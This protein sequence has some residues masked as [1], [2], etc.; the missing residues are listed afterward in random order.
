MQEQVSDIELQASVKGDI[1][2]GQWLHR[3]LRLES[4]ASSWE[5]RAVLPWGG[6]GELDGV[7]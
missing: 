1:P 3:Y 7:S 6:E 2:R 5:R 4:T